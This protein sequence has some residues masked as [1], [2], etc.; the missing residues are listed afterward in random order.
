MNLVRFI[1]TNSVCSTERF[2]VLRYASITRS[3]A[4]IAKPLPNQAPRLSFRTNA[5]PPRLPSTACAVALRFA[6][7]LTSSAVRT[8]PFLPRPRTHGS[9]LQGAIVRPTLSGQRSLIAQCLTGDDTHQGRHVDLFLKMLW[10]F[11]A[12][13]TRLAGASLDTVGLIFQQGKKAGGCGH[14]SPTAQLIGEKCA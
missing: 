12:E 5:K 8:P 10:R 1:R 7:R 9:F 3:M 2:R 11:F 4:F 14:R 6:R 13:E